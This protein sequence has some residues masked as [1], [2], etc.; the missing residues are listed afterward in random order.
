MGATGAPNTHA[1]VTGMPD[2]QQQPAQ[3][4]TQDNKGRS[5]SRRSAEQ[6]PADAL[7]ALQSSIGNAALGKMLGARDRAAEEGPT[8]VD[9]G[10]QGAIDAKQGGGEALEPGMQE[11]MQGI[12]G[13]DLSGVRVHHD[14]ESDALAR[15]LGATAF[16]QG[17]DVFLR[18]DRDPASEPGRNTLAHELSHVAQGSVGPGAVLREPATD[19]PPAP[20]SPQAEYAASQNNFMAPQ[21]NMLMT[22]GAAPTAG[23]APAAAGPAGPGAA[24]GPAPAAA[25]GTADPKNLAPRNLLPGLGAPMEGLMNEAPPQEP[26]SSAAPKSGGDHYDIEYTMY[27]KPEVFKDQDDEGVIHHLDNFGFSVMGDMRMGRQWQESW[28]KE[29]GESFSSRWT[30][31]AA[32]I[33]GGADWPDLSE[34]GKVTATIA[35][36]MQMVR[37][38]RWAV[39][40]AK[41]D[42][43]LDEGAR[44]AAVPLNEQRILDIVAL[45]EKADRDGDKAWNNWVGFLKDTEKGASRTITGLKVAKV[46]GAIAATYL[47]GGAAA[48]L[49]L[50]FWGT[51]AALGVGAG[52][53]GAAQELGNQAGMVWFAGQ[54]SIHWGD[55]A[56]AGAVNAAAGFVGGAIGGKFAGMLGNSLGKMIGGLSPEVM[57]TFGIEGAELLTNGEKI[58]VNWLGGVASSPFVTSTTVLM[59]SALDQ[60]WTVTSVGDFF[61]L[62]LGDMVKNGTIGAFFSYAHA[63]GAGKPGT[64]SESTTGGG[65]G[66]EPGGGGGGG[67]AGDTQL[68]M[69]AAG[70]AGEGAGPRSTAGD[71]QLGMGAAGPAG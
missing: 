67:G 20:G 11:Q 6:V 62:I 55:V 10:T 50:G 23:A 28:I 37:E 27:G 44:K 18:S 53:Y 45:L 69:G 9:P 56:K 36:A 25:S 22:G 12:A 70:P 66:G 59:Q 71:T 4:K 64:V 54:D 38:S 1:E 19:T 43:G 60:K 39:L 47:T 35:E 14:P 51:S 46:A 65:G 33:A 7:M 17:R 48:E 29:N 2:K 32:S 57:E 26:A 5:L 31:A 8:R 52:T 42:S 3:K 63:N 21:P 30:A 58:F 68:G 24:S 34:W 41:G 61:D 16:T 15:G 13:E 49:E 40:A